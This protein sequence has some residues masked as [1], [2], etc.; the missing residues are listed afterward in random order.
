MVDAQDCGTVERYVLD[1][2]YVS[3]ADSIEAAVVVEV[4]GIDVGD[5]GKRSVEPQEAAV[6]L[7]GFHHH[8]IA[9]AQSRVGAVAFDNAAVD[10]SEEHTSELQSREKLVCR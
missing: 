10:R 3:F 5:H 6:A 4:F 1:E 2:L 9:G 8:P 7:V